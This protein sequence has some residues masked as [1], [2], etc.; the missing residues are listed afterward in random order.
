MLAG[1]R[2]LI[3]DDKIEII[4]FLT[5]LLAPLKYRLLTATDGKSGLDVALEQQPDLILLDLHMPGMTGIEVLEALRQ[6][7][8]RSPVI[9][10]TLY[11]SES[12]AVQA[13]RLGVRDYVVKPFRIDELLAAIEQALEVGRLRRERQRLVEELTRTNQELTRRMRELA[14]LQAIG[15]SVASLMP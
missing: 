2:I 15:R 14:T 6:H 1:E 5:D 4:K 7:N 12:V 11:G 9:L 13:F 8:C 3:I 10:M